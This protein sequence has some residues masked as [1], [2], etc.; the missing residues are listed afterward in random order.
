MVYQ[1]SYLSPFLSPFLSPSLSP[2][3]SPYLAPYL[4]L[5]LSIPLPFGGMQAKPL[6]LDGGGFVKRTRERTRERERVR[7]PSQIAAP[8]KAPARKAGFTLVEIMVVVV[9]VGIALSIAVSNLFVG[10]E[11]RV[12]LEAERML[13]LV[14][15]TRDQ[16]VFSGYPIAMRLTA[17]GIAFLE[18]DPNS[19]E[20]IWRNAAAESLRGRSWRDGIRVELAESNTTAGINNRLQRSTAPTSAASTTVSGSATGTALATSSGAREQIVTFLP[21]GIGAPFSMRIFSDQFQ[22]VIEGDALGNVAF[23]Q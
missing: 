16:A 7:H 23:R 14:E 22:R 17:E 5:S 4:S 11:Q 9:I 6:P 8:K 20:P 21:T 3:L 18:R 1:S 19:V 13:V 10:D 12:R 15:K 2:S